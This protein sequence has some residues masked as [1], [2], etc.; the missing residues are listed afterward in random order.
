MMRILSL[1]LAFVG[2]ALAVG[3]SA[4]ALA[5][6][7]TPPPITAGPPNVKRTILQRFDVAGTNLET[8]VAVVEIGASVKAGRHSHPGEVVGYVMDGEFVLA[9]DGQGEQTFKAG[10]SLRVPSGAVHDE[11]TRDKPAR[12]I[13]T[14]VIEKGKPLASPVK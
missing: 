3:A 2:A 8:I 6:Q 7:P 11:G 5:Q 12:L 13:A 14:Y 4:P 10:A 1:G 9:L